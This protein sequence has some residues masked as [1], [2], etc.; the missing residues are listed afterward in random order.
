MIA[1]FLFPGEVRGPV[2]KA[3]VTMRVANQ[4]IS[5][6]WAPAFAGE[7]AGSCGGANG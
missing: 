2:G 3:G 6:N 1:A 4:I 7:Q 5:P